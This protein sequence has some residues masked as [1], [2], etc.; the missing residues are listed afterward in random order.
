MVDDVRAVFPE[1]RI[2]A[3]LGSARPLAQRIAGMLCCDAS[4]SNVHPS[5]AMIVFCLVCDHEHRF[6]GWFQSTEDYERQCGAGAIL[7]PLCGSKRVSRLPSAPHVQSART[8]APPAGDPVPEQPIELRKLLRM[9]QSI[10]EDVGDRF[11]EE[12]RKIHYREAPSRGI[13]G[14]ASLEAVGELEEE[15]IDVLPIPD[16]SRLH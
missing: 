1:I 9:L 15:G 3:L 12:A 16:L 13:R 10:T 4:K 14:R 7:C 5:A 6:E 11:P 8:P 2:L